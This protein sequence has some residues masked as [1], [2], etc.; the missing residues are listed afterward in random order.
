M[1][2]PTQTVS[3]AKTQTQLSQTE[4]VRVPLASSTLEQLTTLRVLLVT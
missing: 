4:L 3:L 2:Q 1:E